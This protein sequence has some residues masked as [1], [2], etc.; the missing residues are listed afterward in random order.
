MSTHPPARGPRPMTFLSLFAGVG[1]FDLAL[2]RLGMRCVG[3][4]EA[5]PAAQRVLARHFPEADRHDDIHT[6]LAWWHA[7]TPRPR[8][9]LV[10]A[11]WPCQDLSQ[12]GRRA[13]LGGP[14]S[15]LFFALAGVVDALHPG[16]LLLENVPGLLT[17]NQGADFQA[18]LDTL[19]ELGY[20][21]AWRVL[22]ARYFGVAQR[23]RRVWLVG[24]RG[25][26]CPF[27][28]L[29]E[30]QGGQGDPAPRGPS[31]PPV[32][33]TLTAG[34]GTAGRT[35]PA[36]RHREDDHNLVVAATLTAN[37][38]DGS[39]RG[40]ASP[41]LLLTPAS[42]S[43][44]VAA[45]L[46]A[47]GG[48]QRTTDLNT[49]L[50]A[51]HEHGGAHQGG[52]RVWSLS[53][54][55]RG[56]LLCATV[57]ANLMVG[58]GKPGQGYP[59]VVIAPEAAV[60]LPAAE[61]TTAATGD[62]AM[63]LPPAHSSGDSSDE[64]VVSGTLTARVGKG[65]S[66][67]GDDGALL[68]QPT[69]DSRLLPLTAMPGLAPAPPPTS[70]HDPLQPARPRPGERRA[71]VVVTVRRLTPTE[72]ERL[73]GFPDDWTAIDGAGQRL[74]DTVR[75]RFMGNAATVP[76]VAWIAARLQA[77]HHATS[78]RQPSPPHRPLSPSQEDSRD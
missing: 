18:V 64:V 14:R 45:T 38:G 39:P 73:Q 43:Q 12:A 29:F 10:C 7:T 19:V 76:V 20:G 67:T 54:N 72:C 40:D 66:S 4:V 53:E 28:I 63:R 35:R 48:G 15:G 34:T 61:P 11:G 26:P 24:R 60:A 49:P 55:Q 2:T 6:T 22:D 47:G 16:W 33:A 8:V 27:E 32:A 77:A 68:V 74:S 25:T 9:D 41:N 50:V 1:G 17:C 70:A 44:Q 37:Y 78:T 5:D 21:V 3:Q 69:A 57:A 30:P 13:G 46:L 65:P 71:D 51:I 62:A 59:A 42:A 36:G 31:G 56:E 58:G 75:Y 23:R 52:G